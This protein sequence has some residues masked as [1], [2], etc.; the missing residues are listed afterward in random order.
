MRSCFTYAYSKEVNVVENTMD[1]IQN[2]VL[3]IC[4]VLDVKFEFGVD[5]YNNYI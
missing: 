1:W 4:R 3:I 2:N 5:S